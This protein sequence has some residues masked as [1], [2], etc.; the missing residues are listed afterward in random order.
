M[1][2]KSRLAVALLFMA[3]VGSCFTTLVA[4]PAIEKTFIANTTNQYL[5]MLVVNPFF[6]NTYQLTITGINPAYNP[7]PSYQTL[8]NSLVTVD[9]YTYVYGWAAGVSYQQY[10]DWTSAD[11]YTVVCSSPSLFSQYGSTVNWDAGTC[12]TTANTIA[13]FIFQQHLSSPTVVPGF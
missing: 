9:S 7:P 6:P 12:Q 1:G 13:Q 2:F 10:R 8:L 11:A 5:S 3:Q 4:P